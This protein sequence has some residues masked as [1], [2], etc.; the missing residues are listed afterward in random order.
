M[1]SEGKVNMLNE[2]GFWEG[3]VIPRTYNDESSLANFQL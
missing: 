3:G 1:A 2:T